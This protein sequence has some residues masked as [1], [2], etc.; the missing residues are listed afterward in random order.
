MFLG[1]DQV[2]ALAM[3]GPSLG[4]ASTIRTALRLAQFLQTL[5]Q[6]VRLEK[7]LACLNLVQNNVTV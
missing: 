6:M 2:T 1:W 3:A 7:Q 4:P 5:D